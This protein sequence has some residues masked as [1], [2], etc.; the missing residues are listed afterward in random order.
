MTDIFTQMARDCGLLAKE[1]NG[2]DRVNLKPSELAFAHLI[3]DHC[4]QIVEPSQYAEA[5]PD[6][7]V[8][9]QAGIDLLNYKATQLKLLK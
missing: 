1:P 7:Y 8:L 9:G 6:N 3:I 4:I 2:F 5:F